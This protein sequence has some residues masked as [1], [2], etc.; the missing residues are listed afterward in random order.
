[1]ED[2]QTKLEEVIKRL[3][4]LEAINKEQQETITK[5]TRALDEIV[6]IKN[7]RDNLLDK[8]TIMTKMNPLKSKYSLDTQL[9]S[10]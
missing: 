9:E 2:I 6:Q 1:M 5:L 10:K 3:E 4:Q 7:D 8:E